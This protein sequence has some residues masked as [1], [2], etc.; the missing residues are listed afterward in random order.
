MSRD[1]LIY[2]FLLLLGIAFGHF[3]RKIN[4]VSIKKA[5]GTIFGL[6]IVL[7]TSKL[8]SLH[9]FLTF[10]LCCAIIKF[11]RS[12]E[13]IQLSFCLFLICDCFRKCHLIVFWFMMI[14][15]LF[16][17]TVHWFGL[18]TPPGHTNMIQM[19]LTLK[20]IG[21]AFER[22]AVLT[23]LRDADKSD[24][25]QL[26]LTAAESNLQNIS[27][28]DIFHYCFNYIGLLTGKRLSPILI[29][30]LNHVSHF[31]PLLHVQNILRL[32]PLAVR[33]QRRLL[34]IHFRETQMGAAVLRTSPRRCLHLAY[35]IRNFRRILF[36]PLVALQTLLRLAIVLHL[37]NAN[38]Q[39]H[40]P[41]GVQLHK[42]RAWCLS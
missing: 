20:I 15:L 17:R 1:D 11:Y 21:L 22:D 14:Y 25:K 16:F 39:W 18:S 6:A 2:G 10:L 29:T 40:Y 28:L 30:K 3:Y 37:P 9:V 13:F 42:C 41:I 26:E 38:L 31:R 5:A 33:C 36:E 35:R 19:I 8:H 12:Y 4:D 34:E 24:D 27:V 7:F 32:P 23:K